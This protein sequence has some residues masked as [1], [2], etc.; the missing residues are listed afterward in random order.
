MN[1]H[2]ATRM[3]LLLA[4]MVLAAC[5]GGDDDTDTPDGGDNNP[6]GDA[7]PGMGESLVEPTGNTF[8][9][10]KGLEWVTPVKGYSI[11]EYEK[12]ND[13]DYTKARGSGDLVRLCLG[14]SNTTG[15]PISVV[16]PVGLI[17]ISS[18]LKTQNGMLVQSVTIEVP[19]AQT[20]FTPLFM[21]CI[22]DGRDPS[23]PEDEF[24]PGP[25]TTYSDFLQ[26]FDLIKN[27]T[28]DEDETGE[29]QAIV[30]NLSNGEGLS[31]DDRAAIN[32]L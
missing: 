31:A 28:I 3:G 30:W 4:T 19:P 7:R 8:T 32:E 13:Q 11:F 1:L 20:F 17:F 15:Q 25:I 2:K 18:S 21:Y 22:N 10:P 5:G 29:V 16:L 14:L 9:L 24:K 26:F 23:T 6:S 27:K 12:C